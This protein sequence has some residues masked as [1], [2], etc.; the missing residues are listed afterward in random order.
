MNLQE[1]KVKNYFFD[2]I[3]PFSK[4]G[5]NDQLYLKCVNDESRVSEMNFYV[6]YDPTPPVIS[7]VVLQNN[8]YG[9]TTKFS[10]DD[11]MVIDF[12]VDSDI[13][14]YYTIEFKN[15]G[16][17]KN[18]TSK[19]ITILENFS[20]DTSFTLQAF[21]KLERESKLVLTNY[22]FDKVNPILEIKVASSSST[23][24]VSCKDGFEDCVRI[25][26]GLS[27][28]NSSC[29]AKTTYSNSTEIDV[30]GV[31]YLCVNGY[32]EA[33]N[34]VSQTVSVGS[35]GGIFIPQPIGD[36]NITPTFDDEPLENST[37][38][39]EDET[40]E[41]FNLTGIQIPDSQ[42]EFNWVLLSAFAFILLLVGT[43]GYY[44]YSRGYLDDQ[45]IAM[46]MKKKKKQEPII[47]TDAYKPIPKKELS[48]SKSPQKGNKY[49]AHLDKLN[50]FI[51]STY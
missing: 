23:R 4:E 6:I 39:F 50:D 24:K 42:D 49:D 19:P 7:E 30:F 35:S 26:Y 2:N 11:Y 8:Y 40:D 47:G 29:T 12:E 48:K 32:D 45:L 9:P 41:D 18:F 16:I 37:P 13:I 25:E 22:E 3:G 31:N 34:K 38:S 17:K 14:E 1:K 5:K 44:A 43:G 15:S 21:D 36:V 28:I 10:K 51:D 33:G 27:S 46:G 20:Q